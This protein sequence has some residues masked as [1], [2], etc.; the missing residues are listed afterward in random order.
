[1]SNIECFC[2]IIPP[3]PWQQLPLQYRYQRPDLLGYYSDTEIAQFATHATR[4]VIEPKKD[5][6]SQKDTFQNGLQSTA[7]SDRYQTSGDESSHISGKRRPS[8]IMPRTSLPQGVGYAECINAGKSRL[9]RIKVKNTLRYFLCH[10]FTF[11]KGTA[12]DFL[13]IVNTIKCAFSNAAI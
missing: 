1:M 4:P 7:S 5:K 12:L 9:G 8:S 2:Y 3:L 6:S 10:K 11:K 13:P